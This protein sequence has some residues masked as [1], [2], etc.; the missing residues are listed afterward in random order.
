MKKHEVITKASKAAQSVWNGVTTA[1]KGI[2]EG[3]RYAVAKLTTSQTMQAIKSK[4]AATAMTIWT[5]VTKAATLA[6]KGLGLAIRFMTGPIGIVITVITA[7]VGA[8][9][10]LWKTNSTFRNAVI[11]A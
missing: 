2:A 6:T 1:A 11:T 10:Y 3:Y 4:I 9:I 7:L 5:G 8:I